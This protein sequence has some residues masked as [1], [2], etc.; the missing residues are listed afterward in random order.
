M[1]SP[2]PDMVLSSL[3]IDGNNA[4]QWFDVNWMQANPDKFQFMLFSRK[5]LSEQCI[6]LGNVTVLFSESC[7]KVLGGNDWWEPDFLRACQFTM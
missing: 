1:A 4:I 2:N 7:V 3:K 6:T 5:T